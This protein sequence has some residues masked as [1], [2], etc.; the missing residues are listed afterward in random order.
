MPPFRPVASANLSLTTSS[1]RV[2]LP[3]TFQSVQKRTV[4]LF[5]DG[6][7]PAFVEFGSST[8]TASTTTSMALPAGW[9]ELFY[10]PESATHVAGITA[11]G[12]ATLRVTTGEGE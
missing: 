12:T 1:D 5:N 2:S 6:L 10:P 11:S 7:V 9:A 3:G 8:V 4:R